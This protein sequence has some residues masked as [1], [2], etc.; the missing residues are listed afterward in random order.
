MTTPHLPPLSP[1]D[2]VRFVSSYVRGLSQMEE[3]TVAAQVEGGYLV[4]PDLANN[5]VWARDELIHIDGDSIPITMSTSGAM[6][7]FC[8]KF[9]VPEDLQGYLSVP[10]CIEHLIADGDIFHTD[11]F[12]VY[13]A[14]E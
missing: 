7:F 6:R 13:R 1:G 14:K 5:G 11:Q 3:G 2:R 12:G 9:E 10:L 4:I 8:R